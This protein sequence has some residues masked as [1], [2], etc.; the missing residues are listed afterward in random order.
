MLGVIAMAGAALVILALI[1]APLSMGEEN[2]LRLLSD[3]S[4]LFGRV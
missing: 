1:N 2:R 3:P 4:W